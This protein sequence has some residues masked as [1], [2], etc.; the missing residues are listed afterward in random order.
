M[1]W[2]GNGII[3]LA[4]Y[5]AYLSGKLE[6]CVLPDDDIKKLFS[7]FLLKKQFIQAVLGVCSRYLAVEKYA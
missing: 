3:D 4:A 2:S 1:N 6:D 5:D 7:S